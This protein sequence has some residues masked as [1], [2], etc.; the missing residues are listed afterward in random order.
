LIK[1]PISKCAIFNLQI[2]GKGV[3]ERRLY[4]KKGGALFGKMNSIHSKTKL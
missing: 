4:L 2:G 1:K 3:L